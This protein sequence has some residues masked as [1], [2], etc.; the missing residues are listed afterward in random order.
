MSGATAE[1]FAEVL[2]DLKT[3]L[4]LDVELDVDVGHAGGEEGDR[5]VGAGGQHVDE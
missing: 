5:V 4:A 2:E 3:S 1:R